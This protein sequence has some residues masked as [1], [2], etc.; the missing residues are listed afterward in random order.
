[1]SIQQSTPPPPMIKLTLKQANALLRC[2]NSEYNDAIYMCDND[3][4]MNKAISY[5][6]KQVNDI[7][8]GMAIEER[9]D[10]ERRNKKCW[11]CGDKGTI[12]NGICSGCLMRN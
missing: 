12:R 11:Y 6:T 8:T 1:M 5:L 9:K 7:E 4:E 2:I 3:K 10:Y